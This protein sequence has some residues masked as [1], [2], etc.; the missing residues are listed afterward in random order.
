MITVLTVVG[1][2]PQ[3]IKA[4]AVSRA[5]QA[6]NPQNRQRPIREILVHTGQHYDAGMSEVFFR[7][8]GIPAP[9]HNLGV[10]SGLHGQQTGR[11]LE[12]LEQVMLQERP[13][14]VLVYG[15]TNS[16]LA[17]GLA[18]S[19]LHIPLAHVEAG[20]RSYRRTMPEE[21]NRVL[22]DHLSSLLFCPTDQAVKNLSCEGI[23]KGVRLVGDVMYDSL[24]YNLEQAPQLSGLLQPHGLHP[25]HYALATIHRAETTD[26]PRIL[27][28]VLDTLGRLELPVLVPLHPRTRAALDSSRQSR[29]A[30]SVRLIE[31]VSYLQMLSLAKGA[32]LILTDSGGVQKEAFWLRVPCITLRAETEW[33]ETVE[34]GW[35]RVVGTEPQAILAAAQAAL[36]TVPHEQ[37][38]PYGDG[39]AAERILET[40]AIELQS[41]S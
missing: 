35:N 8:L 15:D 16:T 4:A 29:V 28:R 13:N 40:L 27:N 33:V 36:K 38:K 25:Q 34:A 17:G 21:I 20:L 10:G 37:G 32:R 31:P 14:C 11:M 39:H 5:F 3:F 6:F 19:K 24:L 2:R 18:A 1:A 23:L 30:A 12:K 9:A 41:Q 26:D 7:E 22:T